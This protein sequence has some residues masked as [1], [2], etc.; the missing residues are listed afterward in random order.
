MLHLRPSGDLFQ[1]VESYTLPVRGYV[2]TPTQR[3]AVVQEATGQDSI[4]LHTMD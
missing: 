3:R 4:I 1:Q 2:R